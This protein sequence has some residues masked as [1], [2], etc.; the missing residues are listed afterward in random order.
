MRIERPYEQLPVWKNL[1][2]FVKMIYMVTSTFPPDEK[3]GLTRKLRN[4]S[5]DIPVSIASGI[6]LRINIESKPY[7]QAAS[8]ALSETETLLFI[9]MQLSIIQPSE[10]ESFQNQ[11][12]A[13]NDE[14]QSLIIRIEK[15]FN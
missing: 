11:I 12:L 13:I 3:E 8:A 6:S 10:F 15:K 9:C 4:R 5:T 14:L 1:M 2:D 7:L